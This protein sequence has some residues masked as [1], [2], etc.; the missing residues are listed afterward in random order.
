MYVSVVSNCCM[1]SRNWSLTLYSAPAFVFLCGELC[2]IKLPKCVFCSEVVHEMLFH[3]SRGKHTCDVGE[4]IAEAPSE[5]SRK[6]CC[7][8]CPYSESPYHK[9]I[10][11]K[12]QTHLN[13][14]EIN[15]RSDSFGTFLHRLQDGKEW[16]RHVKLHSKIYKHIIIY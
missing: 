11:Y 6:A 13:Q 12:F 9:F 1:G 15:S 8:I 16:I 10:S 14:R 3:T 4:L 7:Y 5:I 2:K